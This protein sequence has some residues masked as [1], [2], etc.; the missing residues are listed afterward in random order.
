MNDFA[1]RAI[2]FVMRKTAHVPPITSAE[3]RPFGI[4]VSSAVRL[5][6]RVG[7]ETLLK[8]C[9]YPVSSNRS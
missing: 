9:C 3:L 2:D 5:G 4:R 7:P 8:L 1:L 6:R